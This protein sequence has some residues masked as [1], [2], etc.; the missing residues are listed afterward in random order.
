MAAFSKILLSGSTNGRPIPLNNFTAPGTTIHTTGTSASVID[1]VWLWAYND[2]SSDYVLNVYFGN[3]S[4]GGEAVKITV[5]GS[6]G[7]YLVIP[8][9]TLSGT[10]SSGNI[11]HAYATGVEGDIHVAGYVNRIT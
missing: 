10:G 1:E 4:A 5:R 9:W 6:N 8:G 2:T 11:V 3:Y 7:A